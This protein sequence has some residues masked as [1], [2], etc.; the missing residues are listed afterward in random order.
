MGI[1]RAAGGRDVASQSL[2]GRLPSHRCGMAMIRE[3]FGDDA[4][5][6][7][8]GLGGVRQS[9]PLSAVADAKRTLC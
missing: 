8:S 4:E 6:E 2:Q 3:G 7:K 5:A 1:G 9:R